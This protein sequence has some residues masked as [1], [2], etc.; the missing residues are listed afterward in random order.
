MQGSV[1]RKHS[2]LPGLLWRIGLCCI[3]LATFYP[4]IFML[5]TSLKDTH[6]F[7]HSFWLPTF[8]LRFEN[9]AQA[10]HD[11]SQYLF[12]SLLVTALSLIGI[13]AFSCVSGFLFARYHFPGRSLLYYGIIA[14][15]M[16]PGV[17]ML[18]PSFVWVKSL[19]LIDTYWVMILP[20][21]AGGQV[22]GIYL[23]R[24]FFSE[25]D[26]DLFEAAQVDG[27]GL[28]GQL[29][30]VALPLSRPV[31][32]VVAIVSALG[33]WNNFLWPLV[34]TSSEEVMVLTVG[35]LRY[36][37][38]VGGQYGQMFAGYALSAIPLA[39]L[40]IFSTRLFLK[41]ITSG[42]LKG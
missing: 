26:N 14:M 38:R 27:S 37:S 21:I 40:F 17:L 22:L 2:G 7:Y 33:V 9:Y 32:G 15:M 31:I 28:F 41:G 10:F 4:F 29:W 20:Y 24:G 11:L 1:S 6:Q 30:H 36:N 8:P 3:L 16:I 42:A 23:L 35:I 18:V 19:N 34:T 5:M 13:V 12:N 25:I 39:I